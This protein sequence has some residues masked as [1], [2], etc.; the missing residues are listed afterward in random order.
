MAGKKVIIIDDD[1][2]ICLTLERIFSSMGIS[3]LS[4]N[5]GEEGLCE[6]KNNPFD[7]VFLDINLPDANGLDLIPEIKNFLPDIKIIVITADT[8]DEIMQKAIKGGALM[9]L[10]KSFSLQEIK[11]VVRNVL[12]D[13]VEKR[14]HPRCKCNLLFKFYCSESHISKHIVVPN[15]RY[16]E[17]IDISQNGMRLKLENLIREGEHIRFSGTTKNNSCSDLLPLE[18][19]AEV[20]WV[21]EQSSGYVAGLEYLHRAISG[22]SPIEAY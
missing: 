9:I 18:G 5:S 13:S 1:K 6:I 22:I 8:N 3:A 20:I 11:K 7:M 21:K 10:E 19:A 2:L 17:A 12:F 16:G 14:E 4:V 15:V